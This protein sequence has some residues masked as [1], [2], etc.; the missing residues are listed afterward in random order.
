MKYIIAITIA[1]ASIATQA[2]TPPDNTKLI[3]GASCR[4]F[5]F[6]PSP[7]MEKALEDLAKVANGRKHTEPM[8]KRSIHAGAGTACGLYWAQIV[9]EATLDDVEKNEASN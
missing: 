2:Q 5:V 1:L 4:N 6:Q 3:I 9:C 8:C 7:T